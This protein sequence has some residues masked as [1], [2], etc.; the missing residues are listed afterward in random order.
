MSTPRILPVV[1]GDTSLP[2]L[3]YAALKAAGTHVPEFLNKRLSFQF[4]FELDPSVTYRSRISA[5]VLDPTG[6]DA[7]LLDNSVGKYLNLAEAGQ[8]GLI[9]PLADASQLTYGGLFLYR[10]PDPVTATQLLCGNI[11]DSGGEGGECIQT[12]TSGGITNQ[13]RGY[14]SNPSIS[15]AAI[16]EAGIVHNDWLFVASTSKIVDAENNLTEHTLFVGTPDGPL[17]STVSGEAKDIGDGF[18][19]HAIGCAYRTGTLDEQAIRCASYFGV[20]GDPFTV[21]D[22]EA[23]Y[24]LEKVRAARFGVTVF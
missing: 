22:L 20:A 1:S 16:S 11:T 21:A 12:T 10:D 6:K 5:D 14:A 17:L 7:T 15:S 18:R 2:Q 13:V 19:A 24:A 3:D 8:N 4:S 23:F 9:S